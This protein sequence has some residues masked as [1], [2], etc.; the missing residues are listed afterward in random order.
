ECRI[1]NLRGGQDPVAALRMIALQPG[2]G[3]PHLDTPHSPAV[4]ART[5]V[6]VRSSPREGI[7][8]PLPSDEVHARDALAVDH[9]STP[10]PGA[11]NDPEHHRCASSGTIGGLG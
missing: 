1:G 8:P 4:A 5:G 3:D 10:D 9:D 2:T 6:F 11:E 7:M